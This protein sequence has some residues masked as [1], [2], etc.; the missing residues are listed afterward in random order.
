VN[1]PF[2]PA[3]ATHVADRLPLTLHAY[4]LL[5]T[6]AVPM[7]DGLLRYRLKRGKE[8]NDRMPERR[9]E[10][11][12]ARPDGPLVWLHC[13][14]VGELISILPLIER[15]RSHDI[16]VLVTTGTVT[17][18]AL[19]ERRLPPGV[20]HQFAPIDMPQFV[21]RFLDH[22]RPN[23]ALFVESDLW[24]NLIVASA[25]RN[26]PLILVNGKVS[27]RSFRRWRIAPHMIGALLSRFDLCLAQSAEDAARYANLG[28]QRYFATGNLKLDV[29]APP[30]DTEKL[31][32]LKAAIGTR[33]VIAATSTHP[34]EE[35]AAIDV[36]RRLMHAFP[37]LLTVLAPRHPERGQGISDIVRV[38]GLKFA[39]RSRD[40]L[41]D[42]STE[43]YVVDT[44]GE[45]GL[46]Y[47][48]APIVF[49]GGSLVRHG[50]QNPIEAAKLGAAILHGPHV[51]N[52][53]EIYSALDT[54]GGAELVTDAGKLAVRIGTWLK[55]AEARNK[56]A[57]TGLKAM[58][59][60]AGAL[61]RTMA[62]LDPYLMQFRL[63][64]R[65]GDA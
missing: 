64:R 56:V 3:E 47:R 35:A 31:C 10:S 43:I 23:L 28:A 46:V 38:A 24:P 33:P 61:E 8:H 5:T 50:G 32:A 29:P 7:V 55:D 62:A 1:L 54:A 41:P 20:I 37:G 11:V 9:G 14:S 49:V 65:G 22:W 17:S 48:V 15:I 44:L 30:A 36:H 60:L 25:K 40:Q 27:E 13:A 42:A 4:H 63:E 26:I 58:G 45:L 2:G 53:A 51:W 34:G 6:L 21:K 52:F 39:L 59:T 19:A 12:I 57:Q 16:T 18:A